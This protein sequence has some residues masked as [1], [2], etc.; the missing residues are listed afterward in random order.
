MFRPLALV[1]ALALPVAAVAAPAMSP[2]SYVMK[3]GASDQ[4]EITSSKLEMTSKNPQ[5]REFAQHMIHDHMQST[6]E[7]KAAA[8]RAH[9]H[10]A[11]PHMNAM[12]TRMV[13]QLRAASGAARDR[14]YIQQQKQAHDMALDLHRSYSEQGSAAPLKMAAAKITPV[15]Q[16]HIDMLHTM[17]M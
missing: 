1:A 15:V 7:V 9:L 12:Q 16:S 6:A 8:M 13:A 3:A 5:V 11:P 17:P 4:Y 2:A 10:P 14:L